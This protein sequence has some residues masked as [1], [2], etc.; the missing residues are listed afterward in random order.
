MT[1]GSTEY[2]TKI[3]TRKLPGG[4]GGRKGRSVSEVK[5]SQQSLIRLTRNV[6]T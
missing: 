3:S 4:G 6:G 1:L 5:T 2:L